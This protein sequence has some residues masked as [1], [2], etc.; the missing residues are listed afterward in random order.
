MHLLK[1]YEPTQTFDPMSPAQTTRLVYEWPNYVAKHWNQVPTTAQLRGLRG[2]GMW[3]G[4]PSWA[5]IL[6]VGAGATAVGYAAMAKFGSSHIKPAL[7]KVGINLSG[8]R[9]TRS[10]NTNSEGM[11]WAEWANAARF[12]QGGQL[13]TGAYTA[14]SRGE[15]PTDWAAERSRRR[16]R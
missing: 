4:L 7:R 2:L 5:Q 15:D 3:S 9:R 10:S 1:T 11:T 16:R 13:P 14:W 6:I 8:S 12:G